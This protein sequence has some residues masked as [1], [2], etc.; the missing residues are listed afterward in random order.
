MVGFALQGWPAVDGSS[1]SQGEE[2]IAVRGKTYAFITDSTNEEYPIYITADPVGGNQNDAISNPTV[3]G[4]FAVGGQILFFSP[5]ASTP[6]TLYYQ[7]S[8]GLN[9]G[10]TI[11]VV[12]PTD[13]TQ[14]PVP[15]TLSPA[16]VMANGGNPGSGGQCSFP[17]Q[18]RGVNYTECTCIDVGQAWC[19]LSFKFDTDHRWGYCR[20]SFPQSNLQG[21]GAG[22]SAASLVGTQGSPF[23]VVDQSDQH[24]GSQSQGT[25]SVGSTVGIVAGCIVAIGLAVAVVLVVRHKASGQRISFSDPAPAMP[26]RAFTV[27]PS[28]EDGSRVRRVAVATGAVSYRHEE[29]L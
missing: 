20:G 21:C 24:S 17:F 9:M 8:N 14:P 29:S 26:K 6:S 4:S 5:T 13:T 1:P 25:V 28:E 23:L 22:A 15:T 2:V 10:G 18:Y 16:S 19:A 3:Q 11:S 12:D 7:S 27:A